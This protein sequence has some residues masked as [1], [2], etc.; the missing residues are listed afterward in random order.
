MIKFLARDFL[1]VS[2][3]ILWKNEIPFTVC[4]YTTISSGD[5]QV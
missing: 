2:H 5:I 4:E 3:R 1:G